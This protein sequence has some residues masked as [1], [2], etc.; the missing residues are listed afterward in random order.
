MAPW[1]TDMTGI[2]NWD[3]EKDVWELY[4][5]N[6]DYAESKDLA[7]E[8]PE[9]VAEMKE[10]FEREAADNKV[11]PIGASLYTSLYSPLE[12]PASTVSE[13]NFYEGQV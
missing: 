2:V 3:P 13:W 12:M 11:F 1:S 8:M 9:K 10:L 7:A 6:E 5:L 4:N